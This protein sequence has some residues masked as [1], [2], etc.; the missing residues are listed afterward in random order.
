MTLLFLIFAISQIWNSCPYKQVNCTGLCSGFLDSDSDRICDFSQL[1][2]HER[3]LSQNPAEDAPAVIADSVVNTLEENS[4][5]NSGTAANETLSPVLPGSEDTL[6][7]SGTSQVNIQNTPR[8]TKPITRKYK[9]LP[10]VLI[11]TFLYFLSLLS[12][13][14]KAI[15]KPT[16]IK[17]WNVA[18][19]ISFFVSLTLGLIL[20]F[21]V[22]TGK[23]P[24]FASKV[25]YWHVETA[26]VM[27]VIAFFHLSWHWTYIRNALRKK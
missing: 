22:N 9:I 1:P 15:S 19:F 8:E 18:L 13:R 16:H 5:E 4:A 17:I 26:T 23:I 6:K 14:K 25:L 21:G 7:D 20:I 10:I 12:V 3:I 24:F 11:M 2:P 27:S